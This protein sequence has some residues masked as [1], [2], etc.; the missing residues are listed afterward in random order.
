MKYS[1]ESTSA[2]FS[3]SAG[4]FYNVPF[5]KRFEF[6]ARG[7]LG[8][9]GMNGKNGMN[10]TAGAGLSFMLD[11]NFKIKGFAEYEAIGLLP[12]S[13]WIHS[14]LLGYSVGWFW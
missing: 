3:A 9:A 13:P 14:I 5:A 11:N 7:G 6:Q 10:L 1:V 4:G 2:A 12:A 8:Y